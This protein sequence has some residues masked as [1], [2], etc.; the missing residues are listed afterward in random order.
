[1]EQLELLDESGKP[2]DG[3]IV[4]TLRKLLSRFRRQFPTI[5]DEVEL[6]EV[7]E[8]AGQGMARNERESGM[9]LDKPFGYA[10]A[11]LYA[12]G[13]SKLRG[14][15]IEC[16]RIRAGDRSSS[17]IVVHLPALDGTPEQI[18]RQVLWNELRAQLTPDEEFV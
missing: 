2:L 10:W 12:I 17:E 5:R 14:R 4:A 16:H 8:Q 6:I 13:I 15:S 11:A 18:E 7:F 1:M 3:R 9:L